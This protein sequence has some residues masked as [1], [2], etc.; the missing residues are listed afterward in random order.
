MHFDNT[1]TSRIPF[2]DID[3]ENKVHKAKYDEIIQAVEQIA[4]LTKRTEDSAGIGW[5]R[6]KISIL[7]H[8]IDIAV[9]DLF[10]LNK[11]EKELLTKSN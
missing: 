11:N 9:C 8:Q 1:T 5:G 6:E 10:G 7:Q 2:P 3:T 4:E